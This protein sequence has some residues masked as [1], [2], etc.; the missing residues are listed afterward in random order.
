[1]AESRDWDMHGEDRVENLQVVV[2]DQDQK[3][4]A[5]AAGDQA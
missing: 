4:A 1:M 5:V 2:K 3:A